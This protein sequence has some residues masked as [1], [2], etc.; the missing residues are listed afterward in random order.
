MYNGEEGPVHA[1]TP[2]TEIFPP[3]NVVAK[4]IRMEFV[5]VP[6]AR[7]APVG[8]VQL[9]DVAFVTDP[10]EYETPLSPGVICG[11]PVMVPGVAGIALT[12]TVCGPTDA[13][14]GPLITLTPIVPPVKLLAKFTDIG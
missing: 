5:P 7:V 14:H 4:S 6:D 13:R 3:V 8:M 11:V 1:P 10:T 12:L 9:Y 2:F